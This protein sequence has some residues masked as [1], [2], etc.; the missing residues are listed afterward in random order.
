[1]EPQIDAE[2]VRMHD[3]GAPVL[4][5][6][7][8]LDQIRNESVLGLLRARPKAATATDPGSGKTPLVCMLEHE[9]AGYFADSVCSILSMH[10]SPQL[11]A[12]RFSDGRTVLM[13]AV[14]RCGWAAGR[15]VIAH[16]PR[17]LTVSDPSTR[18]L[19]I[20]QVLESFPLDA[21]YIVPDMIRAYPESAATTTDQ[22]LPALLHY[23]HL[24]HDPNMQ[25]EDIEE[26]EEMVRAIAACGGCKDP[27]VTALVKQILAMSALSIDDEWSFVNA[28]V[29]RRMAETPTVGN[30]VDAFSRAAFE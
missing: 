24:L 17:L 18:T 4:T 16:A 9:E 8:V 15:E 29:F 7:R 3:E 6:H 14:E 12:I 2:L 10:T 28:D 20:Q 27:A 19:P 22:D 30:I 23:F 1:M 21:V 25:W 26:G 13:K 11:E 5:D